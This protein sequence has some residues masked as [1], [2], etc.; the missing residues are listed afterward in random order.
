MYNT[1]RT[2][3]QPVGL[4]VPMYIMC[5]CVC[6]NIRPVDYRPI[7]R[8]RLEVRHGAS[9][10]YTWVGCVLWNESQRGRRGVVRQQF[11]PPRTKLRMTSQ[12]ALWKYCFYSI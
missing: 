9:G 2:L 5:E 12:K 10:S 3:P 1:R 11:A 6:V 4:N 8:A 7:T